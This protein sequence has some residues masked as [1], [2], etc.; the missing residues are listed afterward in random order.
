M[1]EKCL[2]NSEEQKNLYKKHSKILVNELDELAASENL[3]DYPALKGY[4]E[5]RNKFVKAAI[6][7]TDRWA[8]MAEMPG[9]YSLKASADW[10]Q[11]K[12]A[13]KRTLSSLKKCS[14]V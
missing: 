3:K 12:K 14:S 9:G 5:Y 2:A 13:T 10:T 1:R 6:E 11:E 8:V 7:G 4:I